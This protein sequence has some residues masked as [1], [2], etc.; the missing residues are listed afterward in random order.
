MKYI[1]KL[2][3]KLV[4]GE[5]RNPVQGQVQCPEQVFE[6]FKKIKDHAQETLIGVFLDTSLEVRA[7][8]ILSLG[9]DH[10]TVADPVQIFE[11]AILL[12]S[13][14]FILIHN[15]P[16]GNPIPSE[17]D[18]VFITT[19]QEQAKVLNMVLLDFIIVGD[20]KTNEQKIK[21]WSWFEVNSKDC[22][23]DDKN[24]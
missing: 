23:Y 4:K 10:S 20:E 13:K 17:N 8:A 7:Y 12:R 16:S 22:E 2:K 18:F 14:T 11:H 19:L 24:I 6:I 1:K 9:C 3:I 15:H 21:Y 5:Y